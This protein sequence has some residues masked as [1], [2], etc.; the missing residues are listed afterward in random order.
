[1]SVNGDHRIGIFVRTLF[2]C[3]EG[4]CI[5]CFNFH[6]NRQKGQ[7]NLEKSYFSIIG[8]YQIE[9]PFLVIFDQILNLLYL[10]FFSYGPTEQLK[11]VG[12]EREMDFL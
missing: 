10:F 5:S 9:F 1:M 2:T 7:F 11:F 8:K 6:S 3:T 4:I 12:I